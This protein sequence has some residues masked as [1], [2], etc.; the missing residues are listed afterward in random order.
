MPRR[1]I[2]ACLCPG[3][4]HNS[5][6]A[7]MA[8]ALLHSSG[9]M[10]VFYEIG[11]VIGKDVLFLCLHASKEELSLTINSQLAAFAMSLA[12]AAMLREK[13]E[14]AF[15]DSRTIWGGHSVGIWAAAVEAGAVSFE[16]GCL[17]VQERARLMTEAA[18]ERPGKMLV[19]LSREDIDIEAVEA[20]CTDKVRISNYNTPKQFLLG[21][22]TDL[23]DQ[24][25]ETIKRE[26]LI[27]RFIPFPSEGAWHSWCMEWMEKAFMDFLEMVP[28][29]DPEHTMIGN[30]GQ[31][32]TTADA[33][34]EEVEHGPLRPVIW[35]RKSHGAEN[36]VIA[37]LQS[38]GVTRYVE[39][40]AGEVLTNMLPSSLHK[41]RKIAGGV[42][43][44]LLAIASSTVF[45]QRQR[46][47][48]TQRRQEESE[49]GRES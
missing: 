44:G 18:R 30:Q 47:K 31:V 33:L 46:S 48:R 12:N 7:G 40:G 43:V 21:G 42:A 19:G 32:I 38:M 10:K 41:G 23:I 49:E 9:A 14:R 13:G 28:I 22:P 39:V 16:H 3:Q 24:I 5:V 36:G 45:V 35:R 6:F 20:I 17:S 1:R 4:G 11:L 27:S 15:G 25:A 26:R 37:T 34:R 29:G 2:T 8:R